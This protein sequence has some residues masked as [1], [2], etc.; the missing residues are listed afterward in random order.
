MAF[1]A[2]SGTLVEFVVWH[3]F[4]LTIECHFGLKM[5]LSDFSGSKLRDYWKIT[6]KIN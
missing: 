6:R 5:A 4:L 1:F 3:H 2:E